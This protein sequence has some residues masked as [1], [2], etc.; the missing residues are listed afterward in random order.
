MEPLSL[1]VFVVLFGL[2]AFFSAT[3]LALM[4]L[5]SHKIQSFIKQNKFWAKDLK[6]IKQHNDRLLIVILLGTNL[7]NVL[8]A[9]YATQITISLASASGFEQSFA[10]WISAWVITLL[11]FMFGDIF[12]K[13]FA[14]RHADQICLYTATFY[15]YLLRLTLPVVSIIAFVMKLFGTTSQA[16]TITDEEIEAFV[17]EWHK[18][19]IFE[20]WEYEKIRNML[21]FYEVTAQEIMTPRVDIEAL[22][23]DI[24]VADAIEQ[25]AQFSHSRIP[26]YDEDI[27]DIYA[28]VTIRELFLL[29]NQGKSAIAL[30]DLSLRNIIQVPL[31]KPIHKL[32]ELFRKQRQHI[33]VVLDEYGGVAGIVTLEDIIESVFGDIQD[34][35]DKEKQSIRK[36]DTGLHIQ[37]T[38]TMDELLNHLGLEFSHIGISE[39]TFSGETVS[40]FITSFLERFPATGEIINLPVL[41]EDLPRKKLQMTI[42]AVEDNAIGEILVVLK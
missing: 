13:S 7:V 3:E 38:I 30:H 11:S 35:T 2:S 10:L 17:E 6:Y 40:Y 39:D 15:K 31:T 32:L 12:P 27:D 28:F 29:K 23:D 1:F 18:A 4:S 36:K 41:H 24:T 26:V 8:A 9:S 25:V 20:K 42:T 19:G 14:I 34:E 33:A 37:A 21:D 22:E 16:A 5:S